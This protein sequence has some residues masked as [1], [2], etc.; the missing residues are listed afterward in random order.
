[1][2]DSNEPSMAGRACLV[3]KA[4]WDTSNMIL[5]SFFLSL[6]RVGGCFTW[7]KYG[8]ANYFMRYDPDYIN[9]LNRWDAYHQ[10]NARKYAVLPD[11][12]IVSIINDLKSYWHQLM[13]MRY[14]NHHATNK[15]DWL[16]N[17]TCRQTAKAFS[18]QKDP[19]AF[20]IRRDEDM[21]A[22]HHQTS[23]AIAERRLELRA[24]DAGQQ[25]VRTPRLEYLKHRDNPNDFIRNPQVSGIRPKML[26]TEDFEWHAN[27]LFNN[28]DAHPFVRPQLPIFMDK[29]QEKK[30]MGRQFAYKDHM[31][32]K[33]LTGVTPQDEKY[34]MP[35]VYGPYKSAGH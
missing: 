15:L 31:F 26:K 29:E 30:Y 6:P 21:S 17:D 4:G 19:L 35:G 20:F 16:R 13:F 27:G 9:M 28:L 2:A 12:P 3:A 14:E 34:L 22:Y 23:T 18:P 7:L 24:C 33:K 11:W 8:P 10:E 1:M 32:G 25:L 5:G